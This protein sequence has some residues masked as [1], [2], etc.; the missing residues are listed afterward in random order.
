MINALQICAHTKVDVTLAKA[1]IE[2]VLIY[3]IMTT[4][5]PKVCLNEINKIQRTFIWGDENGNRKY[6]VVRWDLVT[7]PK[8]LDG[9]GIQ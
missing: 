2:A 3:L 6:H 9:L 7:S 5:T 4:T 1:V 8:A